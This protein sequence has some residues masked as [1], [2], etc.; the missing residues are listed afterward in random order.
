MNNSRGTSTLMRLTARLSAFVYGVVIIAPGLSLVWTV[1][2]LWLTA[3]NA[4]M[5]VRAI[6]IVML[7]PVAFFIAHRLYSHAER[8]PERHI[9]PIVREIKRFMRELESM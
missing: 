3:I 9:R 1:L 7:V 6:A 2:M 5:V 8:N 4:P